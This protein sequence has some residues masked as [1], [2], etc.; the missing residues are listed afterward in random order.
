MDLPEP[1]GGRLLRRKPQRSR[2][3]SAPPC[4]PCFCLACT[5]PEFLARCRGMLAISP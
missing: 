3:N 5:C 1:I 4:S 2:C